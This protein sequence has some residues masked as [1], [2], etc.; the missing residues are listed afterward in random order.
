MPRDR[1]P[2]NSD[3]AW[4]VML[5]HALHGAD[6]ALEDVAA[7]VTAIFS[8]Y[9][10]GA[11]QPRPLEFDPSTVTLTLPDPSSPHQALA[12][13]SEDDVTSDFERA[14]AQ[15]KANEFD[16]EGNQEVCD[17]ESHNHL[18]IHHYYFKFK[19]RTYC[20]DLPSLTYSPA[21]A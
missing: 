18:S 16:H 12:A 10:P 15:E 13:E 3:A 14:V 4:I 11:C 7:E 21:A 1:R 2:Q 9:L 8:Q 6:V 20:L 17:A 19:G 5:W